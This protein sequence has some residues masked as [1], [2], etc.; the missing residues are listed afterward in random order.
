V[1]KKYVNGWPGL[2]PCK[3]IIILLAVMKRT[4]SDVLFAV[5]RHPLTCFLLWSDM[6][7]EMQEEVRSQCTLLTLLALRMTCKYEQAQ[8]LPKWAATPL[9]TVKRCRTQPDNVERLTL[10]TLDDAGLLTREMLKTGFQLSAVNIPVLADIARTLSYKLPCLVL[11]PAWSKSMSYFEYSA[12]LLAP[13]PWRPSYWTLVVD[14]GPRHKFLV[15]PTKAYP[16]PVRLLD[17]VWIIR[18][19]I[20][21]NQYDAPIAPLFEQLRARGYVK[22]ATE[23]EAAEKT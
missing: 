14:L 18:D 17:A 6:L 19:F 7:S 10:R 3:Y 8:T 4:I 11:N 1:S 16:S 13:V 21:Q 15:P 12:I 22:P 5:R 9:E 2:I 23:E 20:E